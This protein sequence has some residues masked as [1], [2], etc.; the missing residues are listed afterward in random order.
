MN[1]RML[2]IRRFNDCLG[3]LFKGWTE[4]VSY[5]RCIPC[6]IEKSLDVKFADIRTSSYAMGMISREW[7]GF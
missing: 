2:H 5:T 6:W 7:N 3:S 1:G 4:V